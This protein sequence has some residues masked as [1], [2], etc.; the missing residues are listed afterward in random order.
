ML[1]L[2]LRKEFKSP[3]LLSLCSERYLF[4][5][6]INLYRVHSFKISKN[7][8]SQRSL[9]MQGTVHTTAYLRLFYHQGVTYSKTGSRKL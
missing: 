6:F 5:S 7:I 9:Y 1:Y 3:S 8:L 2:S 4:I